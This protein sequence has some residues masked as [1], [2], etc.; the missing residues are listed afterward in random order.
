[1]PAHQGQFNWDVTTFLGHLDPE[2]R[3]TLLEAGAPAHF[4]P[5]DVLLLQGERSRHVYL[6]LRGYVKV[7]ALAE[8]GSESLLGV[9][10]GGDLVGEMAVMDGR[11]R[12]AT[13]RACTP[14]DVRVLQSHELAALVGR[15]PAI[16][17]ALFRMITNRLEWANDR[18]LESAAFSAGTRLCCVLLALASSHGRRVEDGIALAAP[19]TQRDLASL[20]GIK[21]P[22]AEKALRQLQTDKIL[23]LGY[24]T[25]V[26]IDLKRLR[27]TAAA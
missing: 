20:A 14:V 7:I 9:R 18:Q 17:Y 1:M 5:D 25:V 3:S 10:T 26:V 2:T 13:V 16:T 21:L 27:A 23:R 11:P 8:N 6:L 15:S 24:R 12:F 22:T 4:A 19:L